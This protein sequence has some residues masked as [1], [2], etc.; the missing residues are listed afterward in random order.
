MASGEQVV[1]HLRSVGQWISQCIEFVRPFSAGGESGA[2]AG[3]RNFSPR[4]VISITEPA[5][6][7]PSWPSREGGLRGARAD[8]A[9]DMW[10]PLPG[11]SK[12]HAVVLLP[13]IK[14]RK[15]ILSRLRPPPADWNSSITKPSRRFSGRVLPRRRAKRR[16]GM[17]RPRVILA[18]AAAHRVAAFPPARDSSTLVARL[19]AC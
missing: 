9:P 16:D 15:V 6:R 4:S 18:M 19:L 11:T 8:I 1:C 13:L 3:C 10:S 12:R 5:L 14:S 7:W 17:P 2:R